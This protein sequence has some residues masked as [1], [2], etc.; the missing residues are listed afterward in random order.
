MYSLFSLSLK[1]LN[2]FQTFLAQPPGVPE[3]CRKSLVSCPATGGLEL[4][5]LG[6]NFLKETRVVFCQRQDNRTHW[7]E[8]VTPDK[9]FLQQVYYKKIFLYLVVSMSDGGEYL[10]F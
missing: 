1:I 4:Y 8:E 10:N 6:K 9:E 3:V 7:E 2:I 5:L